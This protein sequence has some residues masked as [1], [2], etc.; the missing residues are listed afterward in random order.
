[1]LK[2]MIGVICVM[3]ANVLLGASLAELQKEF[4]KKNLLKGLFK[5]GCIGLAI[6]LMYLCSYL[7]PDIM[8]L[9]IN[10]ID[11]NLIAGIE[12]I[13]IA[14]IV[15][16]GAEDLKKLAKIIKVSTAIETNKKEE[17]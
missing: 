12:V 7:N 5:I 3:F 4:N 2:I 8:V 16:Y 13:G 11:V 1:M 9:N 14:G 6:G 17:K 15:Y 10:G